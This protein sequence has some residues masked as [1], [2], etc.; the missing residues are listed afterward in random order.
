MPYVRNGSRL[1][2]YDYANKLTQLTYYEAKILFFSKIK[3]ISK[4]VVLVKVK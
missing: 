1:S 4:Y 2:L 3:E